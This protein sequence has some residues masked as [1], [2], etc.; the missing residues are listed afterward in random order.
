MPD[1][2]L[3]I[4]AW[5]EQNHRK[6]PWRGEKNP[7]YIWLSEIILQQTQ[8]VQGE[9]YYLKFKKQYPT[10][11][12]LADSEI[13]NVLKLWQGLGYYSRARNLHFAA[14]QV[15]NDFDGI[16][17]TTYKNIIKLK[18]VGEYTAAAISSF[19]FNEPK[20]VV[21][22]NVFRVISRLFKIKTPIN[23]SKGKVE[24]TIIANKLLDKKN[25][26][27]H[28]QAI[29][30]LGAMV[31]KPKN[32]D[33]LNCPLQIK[34]LAFA[35]KTMLNYPIKNKGKKPKK[36]Y[37]NYLILYNNNH[38]IYISKRDKK[39]IWEG[40]YDF[41]LIESNQSIDSI[42]EFE[43]IKVTNSIKEIE[44]KHILTHQH[45]Y[46]SFWLIDVNDKVKLNGY[47]QINKNDINRFPLPQLI[48]R[49][50]TESSFFKR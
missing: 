21:D 46:A 16:F 8:V 29:M 12:D 11:K 26:A 20:A 5:Y 18:G 34:C 37:F 31:C 22:G 47:I 9:S 28:N 3:P 43:T 42:D 36:R 30:E 2:S 48:V 33:C 49:Y 13:E 40:L 24:F 19:V 27:T 23:T 17:P 50:M 45:I 15:M 6:L 44:I 10:I 25:P 14:S 32:P 38:D 1:F 41:P 35:D 39:D 7:Y 4:K